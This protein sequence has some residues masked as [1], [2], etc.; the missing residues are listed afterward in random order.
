MRAALGHRAEILKRPEATGEVEETGETLEANARIKAEAV[1]RAV[2]GGDAAGRGLAALADDSGLEVDALGGAP[3][4]RS[5]RFAGEHADDAANV[6]RLL[7]ALEGVPAPERSARFRCVILALWPD[8]RELM[9][10]GVVEGR[11]GALPRGEGG[12]GYDPVFIP[13]PGNRTF[14]E[15]TLTEKGLLSHRGRALADLVLMLE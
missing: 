1:Q 4:V 11:I 3:G 14:A 15:M 5:A 6:G 12:F 9:A 2:Q 7:A 10:Q 8:G 13:T